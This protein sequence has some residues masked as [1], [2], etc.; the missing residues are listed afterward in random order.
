[1]TGERDAAEQ[2]LDFAA[3]EAAALGVE[4]PNAS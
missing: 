1:M 3:L 4:T 2:A